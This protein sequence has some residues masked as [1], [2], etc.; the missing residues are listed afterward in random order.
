MRG[1]TS[2]NTR[3]WGNF[4]R[5]NS[6]TLRWNDV[7]LCEK[8]TKSKRHITSHLISPPPFLTRIT[9]QIFHKAKIKYKNNYNSLLI[10]FSKKPT[11]YQ[12]LRYHTRDNTIRNLDKL[13]QNVQPRN[14]ATYNYRWNY[15]RGI[16][17]TWIRGNEQGDNK[18]L[19]MNVEV[20]G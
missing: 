8:M 4:L 14:V 9:I 16:N 5:E 7:A 1:N 6:V 18:N 13:C 20:V 10:L 3:I 17:E 11:N 12:N 15:W 19:V 2:L